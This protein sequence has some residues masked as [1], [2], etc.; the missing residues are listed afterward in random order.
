MEPSGLSSTSSP[1]N[2]NMHIRRE[3]VA[4][5][6]S[7]NTHIQSPSRKSTV[8]LLVFFNRPYT[9]LSS[10]IYKKQFSK[11][12]TSLRHGSRQQLKKHMKKMTNPTSHRRHR[13]IDKNLVHLRHTIRQ[14]RDHRSLPTPPLYNLRPKP[15]KVYHQVPQGLVCLVAPIKRSSQPR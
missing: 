13:R 12:I 14:R 4:K 11:V 2:M 15:T 8:L 6:E 10:S 9:V 5:R 3:C 1:E 7:K